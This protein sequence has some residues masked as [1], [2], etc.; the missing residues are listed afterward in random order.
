MMCSGRI[1]LRPIDVSE[2]KGCNDR[3]LVPRKNSKFGVGFLY[4]VIPEYVNRGDPEDILQVEDYDRLS[5]DAKGCYIK[6]FVIYFAEAL[7]E[8]IHDNVPFLAQMFADAYNRMYPEA[9]INERELWS[10]RACEKGISDLDLFYFDRALENRN[11]KYLRYVANNTST[12]DDP[13]G[14]FARVAREALKSLDEL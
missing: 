2:L 11:L 5:K 4:L 6:T 10:Q 1:T 3:F 12:K 9:A 13:H 8:R 7:W 14:N